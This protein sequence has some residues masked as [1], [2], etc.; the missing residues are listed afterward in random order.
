MEFGYY[1]T[2]FRGFATASAILIAFEFAI[3]TSLEP[4]I[5]TLLKP[6]I[7]TIGVTM[8]LAFACLTTI[9]GAQL[10]RNATL[11]LSST[12]RTRLD[13]PTGSTEGCL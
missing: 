7:T 2:H 13:Q 12:H 6:A 4:A 11:L 3:A 5:A 10:P 1:F 9:G 8:L